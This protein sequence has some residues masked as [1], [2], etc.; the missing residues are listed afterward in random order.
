MV[1][2]FQALDDDGDGQLT[3]AELAAA[4]KA[5]GRMMPTPA[6]QGA[7]GATPAPGMGTMPGMGNMDQDG[8]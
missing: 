2:R 5:M 4:A 6:P 1:D 3:E 8:N 7:P